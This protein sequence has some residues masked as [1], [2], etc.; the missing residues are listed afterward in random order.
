[1]TLM[2]TVILIMTQIIMI[3][4]CS[5][6]CSAPSHHYFASSS[7][8]SSEPIKDNSRVKS[9]NSLRGNLWELDK[10]KMI[11]HISVQVQWGKSKGKING[12]INE[13]D[14]KK[15]ISHISLQW[16]K[17][18]RKVNEKKSMKWI[19]RE[20]SLTYPC[21]CSL[22]F[23][24]FIF[25]SSVRTII[26][27]PHMWSHWSSTWPDVACITLSGQRLLGLLVMTTTMM[28]MT[29]MLILT[30]PSTLCPVK[31]ML[32]GLSRTTCKWPLVI[33]DKSRAQP[34]KGDS[35]HCHKWSASTVL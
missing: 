22:I 2:A 12:K 13:M 9:N 3:I 27:C 19:T 21:P 23:K 30:L 17:S 32:E 25:F 10:K 16:G 7:A 4:T 14:K 8:Q 20:L 28:M 15:R 24:C 5:V 1:M 31:K 11:S 29:T 6:Q 26:T 35:F 33:H 34:A 18:K